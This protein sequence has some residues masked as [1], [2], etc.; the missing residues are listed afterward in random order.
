MSSKV[1]G[2]V[3]VVTLA[4]ILSP[5]AGGC[6]SKH[7]T[8]PQWQK[9][10][11]TYITKEGAGDPNILRDVTWHD[12]Q[13]GFV[14]LG[15]PRADEGTDARGALLG[16]RMADGKGWYVFLVGIV[17]QNQVQDIRLAALSVNAG[18]YR[19]LISPK[20]D[21]AFQAYRQYN[22]RLWRER[23]PGRAKPPPEY[24]TFP[25]E[26]DDFE[27]TVESN[28]F[29]AVHKASGARWTLPLAGGG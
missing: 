23:F 5:L 7:V 8:L 9:S 17:K 26:E 6:T 2:A 15:A 21:T 3:V 19:W 14:V 11:E 22:D 12:T 27:L 10:V 16:H 4:L 29:V 28:A 25:R 13:H 18:K 24:A 20:D 1:N